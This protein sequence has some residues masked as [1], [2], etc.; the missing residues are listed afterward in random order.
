MDE[1]EEGGV[2]KKIILVTLMAAMIATPCFAQEVEPDG[3]ISIGG[4]IWHALPMGVQ[5]L[6]FPFLVSLDWKF[7]FY[8]G[9][10]CNFYSVGECWGHDYSFYID[11]LVCSIFGAF[12]VGSGVSGPTTWYFGILQ[13][14]GIGIVVEYVG[15]GFSPERYLKIGLLMKT[16]NNW[17]PP[18]V[19]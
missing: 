18:E 15:P 13:P 3:I 7:G 12:D 2:M 1:C 8:D 4:T 14:I 6:P 19:E 5:I 11:M 16:D 17:E 10:V 9:E